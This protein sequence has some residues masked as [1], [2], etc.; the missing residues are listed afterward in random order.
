VHSRGSL[1]I[2]KVEQGDTMWIHQ[3]SPRR[4]RLIGRYEYPGQG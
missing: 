2:E 4:V 3:Y 1:G